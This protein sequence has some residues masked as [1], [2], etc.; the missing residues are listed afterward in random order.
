MST[1]SVFHHPEFH[2]HAEV[3]FHQDPESGLKSIIALHNTSCGVALG[4]TRMLPYTDTEEALRD[5]LRLSRGM[6]YKAAVANLS[7][8]GGK[9]VILGDPRTEKTKELLRAQ[10]RAVCA[11]GTTFITAEDSGINKTDISVMANEAERVTKGTSL[12]NFPFFVGRSKREGGSGDP[13]P[14]TAQGVLVSIKS[15]LQMVFG[16][17]KL[18]GR[19]FGIQGIGGSVGLELACLILRQGGKV[20]GTE[21][22]PANLKKSL[23]VLSVFDQFID[24][25]GNRTETIYSAPMDVF[26]PCALGGTLNKKTI[27]K[28]RCKIIVG[29]ANNQLQEASDGKTLHDMRIT[30]VPDYIANAGGLINVYR[31][32]C[33]R[34]QK[35]N[36]DP[37]SDGMWVKQH[38]ERIG[39]TVVEILERS[40][41]ES[42]PPSVIADQ[43]ARERIIERKRSCAS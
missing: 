42:T 1:F 29:C 39:N 7:L 36:Y 4:G 12:E 28:L 3:T 16:D 24:A 19:I 17:D 15:S 18:Q 26:M 2:D 34:L 9:S 31:E 5:A 41:V 38:I 10:A 33:A 11:H 22:N 37:D 21:T 13:S 20:F 35:R 43:I 8:G 40:K 14:Y 25:S 32:F 6:T 23:K 30:Y 27:P